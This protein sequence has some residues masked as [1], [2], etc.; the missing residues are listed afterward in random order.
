MEPSS[1]LL[2]PGELL[3]VLSSVQGWGMGRC[4][5]VCWEGGPFP[6][7]LLE[8]SLEL[9]PSRE[10]KSVTLAGAAGR[11]GGSSGCQVVQE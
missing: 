9:R 5:E 7:L 10:A 1:G 8:W 6:Y 3:Q 11:R 2:W 4:M